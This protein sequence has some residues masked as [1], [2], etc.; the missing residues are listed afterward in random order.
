MTEYRP[1]RK[2][3]LSCASAA[4]LQ[5]DNASNAASAAIVVVV[6]MTGPLPSELT[7]KAAYC[8]RAERW[9]QTA[10]ILPGYG[11]GTSV[12]RAGRHGSRGDGRLGLREPDLGRS[13]RVGRPGGRGIDVEHGQK[14]RR[15]QLRGPERL[16]GLR[17]E[18]VEHGRIGVPAAQ[19]HRAKRNPAAQV[20]EFGN[21]TQRVL[22]IDRRQT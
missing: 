5:R 21:D 8:G 4:S 17:V 16:H 11:G 6:F 22:R 19:N 13:E 20:V 18:R 10:V 3:L 14:L 15:N 1:T 7:E 2:I 12:G 9:N